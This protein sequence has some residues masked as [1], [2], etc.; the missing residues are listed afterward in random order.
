MIA[1]DL[2]GIVEGLGHDVIAVARTHADAVRASQRE[3]PGLVLADIQL[4][5]RSSGLDAVN[6][7]LQAFSVP[8]IFITAYPDRLLTGARPEPAFLI[9]KHYQPET[10]NE[11]TSHALLFSVD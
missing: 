2:E 4:A 10:V 9:T 5:D 3:T 6:Q 7:M 8:V 1:L 11:I